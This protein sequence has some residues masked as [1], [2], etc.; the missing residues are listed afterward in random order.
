ME[1]RI[2]S[3]TCQTSLHL[4]LLDY[5]TYRMECTYISNLRFLDKIELGRLIKEIEEIPTDACS[6]W[7]WND[8][9]CYLTCQNE[10]EK[11]PESAQAKLISLLKNM[12]NS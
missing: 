3:E 8:A 2:P 1:T 10:P 5:L 4:P 11:T 6:L 12:M 9:L 7:E